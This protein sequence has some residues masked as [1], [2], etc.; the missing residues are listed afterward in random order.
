[1]KKNIIETSEELQIIQ[2][3]E[4]DNFES[5][6]KNEFKEFKSLLQ[7]ASKNTIEKL[8]KKKSI[9]IRLLEDDIQ[10][11]KAQAINLGMPYQTLISSI[12]HQYSHG[13]LSK[14]V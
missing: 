12:I 7:E 1:M 8:S 5:L 11:L 2:D 4:N 13:Q 14:A 9:S 6:D 10:R 3:V